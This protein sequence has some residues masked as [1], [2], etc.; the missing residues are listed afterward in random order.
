VPESSDNLE[1]FFL[2]ILT[3][4]SIP[5]SIPNTVRP[6]CPN[7]DQPESLLYET[8]C[9]EQISPNAFHPFNPEPRCPTPTRK[10]RNGYV[11]LSYQ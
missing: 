8:N 10:F 3:M 11:I 5:L 1:I 2:C 7:S 4:R 6:V 9:S